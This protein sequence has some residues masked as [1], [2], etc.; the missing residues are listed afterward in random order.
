LKIDV[1]LAP[2]LLTRT[3]LDGALCG[4][5][6]V[7]RATTSMVTALAH[8]A[9]EILP[10][11]SDVEARARAAAMTDHSYLL[12]GEKGG[13][14]IAG[15]SLGNSPLEYMSPDKMTGKS[16][17]FVTTN[18]TPTIKRAQLESGQPTYIIAL[19]NATAAARAMQEAVSAAAIPKI[20]LICSGRV[21]GISAEDLYCAG[22]VV[23]RLEAGLLGAG[24]TPDL[25]DGALIAAGFADSYEGKSLAIL[26][27]SEWGR[28]LQGI[29]FFD[30]M[31]YASSVDVYRIAPVFDGKRIALKG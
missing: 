31:E 6:D 5:I 8:G 30:D 27:A 3:K 22:M 13:R 1:V 16:L 9:L 7:L 15:F 2:R 14:R 29:G 24:F 26:A 4:V 11:L 17:L 20:L 28:R 10:C 25:G 12:C 21:G 23:R 19:V 18:G